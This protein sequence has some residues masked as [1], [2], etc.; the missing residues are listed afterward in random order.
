MNK[1][2]EQGTLKTALRYLDDTK[3]KLRPKNPNTFICT[4]MQFAEQTGRHEGSFSEF[5][6][7]THCCR[8]IYWMLKE[9]FSESERYNLLSRSFEKSNTFAVMSTLIYYAEPNERNDALLND[10]DLIKLK[11]EWVD[12]LELTLRNDPLSILKNERL[13]MILVA[14]QEYGDKTAARKW[15]AKHIEDNEENLFEFLN[16]VSHKIEKNSLGSAAIKIEYK[17]DPK[18]IN[19]F[20][21]FNK[22]LKK[23]GS[24]DPKNLNEEKRILIE[25]LDIEKIEESKPSFFNQPV[26]Q[27]SL[28]EYS[29]WLFSDLPIKENIEELLLQDIDKR[30]YSTISNLN[31]AYENSK[32]FLK[33]YEEKNPS[34]FTASTDYLTK[35]LGYIDKD[36]LQRHAF[37]QET[38]KAIKEFKDLEKQ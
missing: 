2:K 38:R 26:N 31:Q 37:G 8:I 4:L 17:I 12:K 32:E 34:A 21:D 30:K 36:F 6:S 35:A 9:Q 27:E 15:F 13:V 10:G 14:W 3:T 5:D 18:T 28:R 24:I 33:W 16:A 23:I 19:R 25:R 1:L 20:T 7:F 29:K 22:I 11:N